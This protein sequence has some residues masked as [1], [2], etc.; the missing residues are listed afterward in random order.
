MCAVERLAYHQ[1]F[2]RC[3]V[4][5]AYFEVV[6]T[7]CYTGEGNV[8]RFVGCCKLLLEQE[9]AIRR[10]EAYFSPCERFGKQEFH[11]CAGSN[12]VGQDGEVEAK[13]TAKTACPDQ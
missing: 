12:R 9:L 8:Y 5:A 4:S 1:F 2:N 11:L 6:C 7:C 10:H 13:L 3:V